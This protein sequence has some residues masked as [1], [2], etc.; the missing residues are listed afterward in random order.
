MTLHSTLHS[1]LHLTLVTAPP[2]EQ[3]VRELVL[4]TALLDTGTKVSRSVLMLAGTS[5]LTVRG[6][7]LDTLTPGLFPLVNGAVVVAGAS[8]PVGGTSEPSLVLVI[9]TGPD[10][11][12]L[13]P[14]GRGRHTIGRSCCN[15][16]IRDPGLSR[17][18]AT[19]SVGKERIT[20]SDQDSA[21]GT[22]VDGVRITESAVTT[23][24]TIACGSST[25][26]IALLGLPTDSAAAGGPSDGRP[27]R[28][29]GSGDP[30][31]DI[32]LEVDAT[33]P[34]ER[35]RI[36]FITAFL[37]LVLGVVLALTTGMWFFLA[38]SALSA[39]TG[40]L[41][42]MVHRRR[43]KAFDAA[44]GRAAVRDGERR[45]RAVPDAG[46]VAVSAATGK[47]PAVPHPASPAR[48][49]LR[50]G[51]ADQRANLVVRGSPPGWEP[52]LL[53]RLPC[54]VG[55]E[56][57][58]SEEAELHFRGEPSELAGLAQLLLLQISFGY[59]GAV[60]V[61]CWGSL[62]DL[63]S[64]ARFLPG[65]EIVTHPGKLE[66][67]L[68]GG[69]RYL[70]FAFGARP[71]PRTTGRP[72]G[73]LYFQ[74]CP[75][76]AAAVVTLQHGGAVLT[77]GS[78]VLHFTPD[79]VRVQAFARTARALGGTGLGP[80][81]PAPDHLPATAAPA[82]R[83]DGIPASPTVLARWRETRNS[84]GLGCSIGIGAGGA[85]SFDLVRDGPHL[86][87]AG[88]TGSGK[89]EFL[90][91]LL[92]GIAANHSPVRVNFLLVD[93]KGGSG[94][95]KLARLPHTVGFLSDLSTESVTRSL[96]S[97][98]AELSRREAIL[99]QHGVQDVSELPRG[100]GFSTLPRL[101]VV[102]D[103][104]RMLADDVPGAVAGLMRVAAL[105]RSLG[106][107]LVMATQRP[108]GAIT[109]DIRAN[110]TS[111]VAFRV[112][113]GMDSQDIIGSPAAAKI[114]VTLPGRG[115]IR[116]GSGAPSLFQAASVSHWGTRPPVSG[117]EELSAHLAADQTAGLDPAG[118]QV[119]SAGS[120]AEADDTVAA[121]V[122]AVAA[123]G[124]AGGYP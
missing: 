55:I 37:P 41:P 13:I 2:G 64:A 100:A 101:I 95:G 18:H 17:H 27:A 103:E 102:I 1:T 9:S 4:D 111:A 11:G 48:I 93:F 65:V 33:P 21:N 68:Q 36:Q 45:R 94:L 97:L 110:I 23:G 56:L 28:A 74:P 59:A 19:L 73:V 112:Q 43:S 80:A 54:L 83:G 87:V 38:F 44:V 114:P 10:A 63:P 109:P 49:H 52:P 46:T 35:S 7:P 117:L 53:A 5:V 91:T 14:L 124:A 115:I 47:H 79:L 81:H 96:V 22:R 57:D 119:A 20:I 66:L 75:D 16:L 58:R 42:L 8:A 15:I 3:S 113:T 99:A 116:V 60:Q 25:C 31:P 123:A 89:S 85:L 86:L 104:F 84:L 106:M 39:V 62:P 78:A 34:P 90:R 26:R 6:L 77:R 69:S 30:D 51:L 92:L 118:G 105:G 120:V 61:L 82:G 29:A 121:A 72:A 50:L 24:S 32:P 76:T 12:R 67:L 108:Q 71:L 70:V 98:R 88:T 40:V 107:H 122:T